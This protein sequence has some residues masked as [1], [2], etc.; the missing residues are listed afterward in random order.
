MKNARKIYAEAYGMSLEKLARGD[1]SQTNKPK[2]NVCLNCGRDYPEKKA[3]QDN[4]CSN[5]WIDAQ[6][7]E[8]ENRKGE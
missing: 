1:I 8:R 2:P 6:K 3:L 7:L 4:I 5:C